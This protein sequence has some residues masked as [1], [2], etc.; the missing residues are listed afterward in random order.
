[1]LRNRLKNMDLRITELADY[2]Q[3]SRPTMY[4]FIEYYENSSFDLINRKTLK[5][6]N[7]IVENELAGKKNVINYILN[8]LVELKEMGDSEEKD[9]IKTMKKFI[10]SNP[11]SKKSKFIEYCV[12]K[13]TFDDIIYYL[14]EI[15]DLLNKRKLMDDEAQSLKPYKEFL[16]KIEEFNKRKGE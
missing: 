7:Y 11:E 14:M 4:K 12:L 8:N 9:F 10:V 13:N 1:M 15:K 16:I 5:L 3:V 2:M 6:F